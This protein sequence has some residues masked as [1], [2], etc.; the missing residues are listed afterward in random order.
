MHHFHGWDW[1]HRWATLF[2]AVSA[3]SSGSSSL[4]C[5]LNIYLSN[6]WAIQFCS[7]SLVI[8]K[9]LACSYDASVPL[10][11]HCLRSKGFVCWLADCHTKIQNLT[12][13]QNG[14]HGCKTFP[15]M[16]AMFVLLLQVAVASQR[17]HQLTE[18][19][20]GPWW[21]CFCRLWIQISLTSNNYEWLMRPVP[22]LPEQLLW[23]LTSLYKTSSNRLSKEIPAMSY[24]Q[25][26]S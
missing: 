13:D 1:C 26:M 4:G 22:N 18:K 20:R 5:H 21:R 12:V 8:L 24:L 15:K 6:L 2:T 17:E 25:R 14:S 19:S 11:V 16:D 23:D 9:M 7:A 10:L 3:S